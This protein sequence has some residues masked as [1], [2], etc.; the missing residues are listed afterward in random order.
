MLIVLSLSISAQSFS[1]SNT[2][3]GNTNTLEGTNLFTS[4]SLLAPEEIGPANF[5]NFAMSD[6]LQADADTKYFEGRA[7]FDLYNINFAGI[8][9]DF[10]FRGYAKAGIPYISL[11][12]GNSFFSK[13]EIKAA[14]ISAL[15]AVPNYGKVLKNGLGLYSEIPFSKK[16]KLKLGT[17]VESDSLFGLEEFALD[18]GF[19][20]VIKNKFSIGSSLRDVTSGAYGKYSV[21]AGGNVG[22]FRINGGYIY[23]NTDLQILPAESKHSIQASVTYNLKSK[24]IKTGSVLVTGLTPE[25]LKGKKETTKRYA[26][27]AVPFMAALFFNYKFSEP[28]LEL[29]LRIKYATM[30]HAANSTI[31]QIH[32]NLN[33]VFCNDM[34]ELNGGL[35]FDVTNV[36]G[37]NELIFS[38]PVSLKFTWQT[39][40]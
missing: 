23:N 14:E 18:F 15:D 39:K 3:G 34:L 12:F 11:V 35:N 4:S 33:Y 10:L 38:L 8:S 28:D 17:A 32:P 16:N 24:G 27:D 9:P 13:F 40:N 2:F 22:D 31:V 5:A 25:Y 7:R 37:K 6:R 36:A 1:V 19:D 21:F 30:L 26:N 29:G 20:Y